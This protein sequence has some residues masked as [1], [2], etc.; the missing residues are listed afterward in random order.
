MLLLDLY[1]SAAW[2]ILSLTSTSLSSLLSI[3]EASLYEPWSDSACIHICQ[4]GAVKDLYL[5]CT[6]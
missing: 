5:H 3:R 1:A 6:R 4:E 2:V